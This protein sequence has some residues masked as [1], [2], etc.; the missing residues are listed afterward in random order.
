MNLACAVIDDEPLARE[1]MV[2]YLR[3]IDF[4]E[5]AATGNNPVEL[6]RI[7]SEEKI[8][9]IFLDIQMPVMNGIEFLKLTRDLPMVIITTAYPNY[10]LEGFQFDVID[11]LVKPITFN[12]FFKAV[13]KAKDFYLLKNR[14]SDKVSPQ[15]N[16]DR[17]YFFIRCES[18]YER[19]FLDEILYIEA[20]QNYISIVTVKGK[21]ITL[22][23]MKNVEQ[24]LAGHSFIRVHKSYI[25]SIPKIQTIE[26]NEVVLPNHRI[27]VSR[28]YKEEVLGKVL[29]NKLWTR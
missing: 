21:F 11:Y 9:L 3:E 29:S 27:P 6:S 15:D 18:R 16:F 28:N 7:L 17:H 26:N 24:N 1:C 13:S 20:M 25:V 2:N 12:R 14:N 19:I 5:L 22:L 10:A 8:D 23:S 4:L